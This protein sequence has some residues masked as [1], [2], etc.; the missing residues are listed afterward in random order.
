M[1]GNSLRLWLREET[2]ARHDALDGLVR[3]LDLLGSRD[4]FRRLLLAHASAYRALDPFLSG[5]GAEAALPD[6]CRRR[7]LP[8]IERD[9]GA[10]G[11]PLPAPA[12]FA[13]PEGT[14]ALLGLFYVTEGSTLGGALLAREAAALGFGPGR[15]ASFLDPY[16]PERGLLWR[17][18]VA[19]LDANDEARRE[20]QAVARA[21]ETAFDLFAAALV[22]AACKDGP[23][24]RV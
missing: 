17:R 10:L 9:L 14:P 1:V 13:P 11:L 21:A 12:P 23:E 8:L 15:G 19:S 7:R 3:R 18:F 6:A 5:T 20:P 4:G 2:R 16:G 24:I 22:Q